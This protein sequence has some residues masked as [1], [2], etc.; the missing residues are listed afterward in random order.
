MAILTPVAGKLFR[1]SAATTVG[2]SYTVVKGMNASEKTTNRT[3]ETTDTFDATNA[4]TDTGSREKTYAINGLLIPD[5]PGQIMVRDAE[6]VDTVLFFKFLP[7]GGSAYATENVRGFT[8]ACKAGS[9]RWGAQT[10]GAQ[11]WGF[12]LVSQGDEVITTGGYII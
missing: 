1:V 7:V 5:D 4:F 12:D 6:R 11:T 8:H 3:T 9:T 2:G 10:S